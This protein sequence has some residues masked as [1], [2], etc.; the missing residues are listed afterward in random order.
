MRNSHSGFL[1]PAGAGPPGTHPLKWGLD[2][3]HRSLAGLAWSES[4][5]VGIQL[6]AEI[7]A[8]L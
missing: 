4:F 5:V 6:L 7:R 1:V 3:D 8:L 2:D